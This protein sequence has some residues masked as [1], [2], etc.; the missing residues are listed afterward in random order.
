MQIGN[1]WLQ[2]FLGLILLAAVMIDRYRGVYAE[3]RSLGRKDTSR[4]SGRRA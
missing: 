4:K 3:R 2:L 1:F